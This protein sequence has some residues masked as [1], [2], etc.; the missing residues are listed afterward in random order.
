MNLSFLNIPF[1]VRVLV[2]VL[3]QALFF[4]N[5]TLFNIAK[6]FFYILL[7][8]Y[9][10]IMTTRWLSLVIAFIIGF[11]VDIFYNSYGIQS[12]AC[13]FVAYYRDFILHNILGVNATDNEGKEPHLQELGL[14]AFMVYTSIFTVLHHGLVFLLDAFSFSNFLFLI[15]K[16]LI[17][18]FF[19]ILMIMMIEI[20][21]FYGLKRR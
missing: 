3:L 4:N 2:V 13:V 6:P 8:L 15:F 17:N 9:L 16:V 18:S 7:I 14:S 10:P 1:L 12:A 21:F 20:V 5:L 19:T 11:S